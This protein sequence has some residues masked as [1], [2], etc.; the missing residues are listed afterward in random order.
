LPSGDLPPPISGRP[1]D[2]IAKALGIAR[3]PCDA[4]P[5]LA[6]SKP[7]WSGS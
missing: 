5:R 3:G 1:V 4:P 7:F 6:G 2:T